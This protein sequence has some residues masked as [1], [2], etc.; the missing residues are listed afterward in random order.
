MI[1]NLKIMVFMGLQ[2]SM[3]SNEWTICFRTCHKSMSARLWMSLYEIH[4]MM[5]L[6]SFTPHAYL[7]KRTMT[8]P[9]CAT[10]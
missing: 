2:K 7:G 5:D 8:E 3:R 9:N 10:Y 4:A 1:P 6:R